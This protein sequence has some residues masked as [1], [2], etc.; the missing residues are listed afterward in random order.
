MSIYCELG[1]T[2]SILRYSSSISLFILRPVT[3]KHSPYIT[4]ILVGIRTLYLPITS[5]ALLLQNFSVGLLVLTGTSNDDVYW[6]LY[7][8]LIW[9]VPGSIL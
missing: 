3:R 1:S 8:L 5:Q 2:W 7:L 4:D 9:E 6:I